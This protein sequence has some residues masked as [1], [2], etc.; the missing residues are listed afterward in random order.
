MNRQVIK[1]SLEM[2]KQLQSNSII[3]IL[4]LGKLGNRNNKEPKSTSTLSN[5]FYLAKTDKNKERGTIPTLKN[6][7]NGLDGGNPKL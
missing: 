5:S 6:N 1:N 3:T 7:N 4:K 2:N